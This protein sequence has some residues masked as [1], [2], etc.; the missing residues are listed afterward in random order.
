LS[1]LNL[2]V[3]L[4]KK[5]KKS[6]HNTKKQK[7]KETGKLSYVHNF[8]ESDV[9]V[10]EKAPKPTSTRRKSGSQTPALPDEPQ[11]EPY[12]ANIVIHTFLL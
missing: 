2:L 9:E 1:L 10:I 3:V 5:T 12:S 4:T 8:A 6:K 11:A 7:T